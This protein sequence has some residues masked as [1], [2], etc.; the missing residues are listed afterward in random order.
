MTR[1]IATFSALALLSPLLAACAGD[2][3]RYPSLAIREAERVSGELEP[4]PP[5]EP[6]DLAILP[7]V[8]SSDI[9]SLVEQASALNRSF[10]AKVGSVRA[11]ATQARGTGRDSEARGRAIVALADLTSLRSQ[12]EVP[13]GDLDLLVAERTNRLEPADA[14][15][16]AHAQVK[17]LV[18]AQNRTLAQLWSLLDQ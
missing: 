2:S 8:P 11:L 18:D 9:D 13:L 15:L 10:A 4:A 5:V 14:A 1:T 16:A 6:V 12:T 7:L 3:S 17:E